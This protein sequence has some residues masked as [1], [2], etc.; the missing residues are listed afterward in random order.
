MHVTD[1]KAMREMDRRAVSEYG[2]PG[3]LLMENAAMAVMKHLDLSLHY[4]VLVCGPGN[5]GGDGFA[6][7]WKLQKLNKEVD[8]FYVSDGKEPEGEA[9]VYYDIIRKTDVPVEVV[10]DA[11]SLWSFVEALRDADLVVDALL[12]TGISR[13]ISPLFREVIEY[14]NDFSE[15]IL[16]VDVPSGLSADS[17]LAMPLAVKASKTVTFEAM[18]KGLL[19]YGAIPCT[20]ILVMEKIGIP[21]R[22]KEELAGSVYLTDEEDVMKILPKREVT[23][24]KNHYGRVL[25]VAG[26]RG[27]TGAAMLSAEAALA[28]GS[29][30]VT[31]CSYNETM[32]IL[33][34]RLTEIMSLYENN[35][36]E[37][38][39]KAD[40]VA[41]GPGLGASRD[42][43][44]L[45]LRV[46][47]TLQEEEK[48]GSTL[49]I[50]ADGLNVLEGKC[51]ILKPLCF[52]VILTPHPGEMA[53][54]TGK[55]KKEIEE[56]RIETA[57]GFAKEH[58]V[59]VVLKGYHT[60]ITDGERVYINSTG[61]SAMA[62][63]G[64]GDALT[65]IIASLSGQG[66][67]P[68]EA[69]VLGTYIHGCIGDQLAKERYSVKASEIIE[70]IPY[71]MK[72]LQ[73]R[74]KS[75]SQ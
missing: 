43:L 26:S 11:E 27:F 41:F 38:V 18:K 20:G 64:M 47:K 73:F 8:V 12:G 21:D 70:K 34:P 15:K 65:G 19:S 44:K 36:E 31:L 48:T 71:Y 46:I 17:G 74:K 2:I 62:Q 57:K 49:V 61:T 14:M 51:E 67:P 59:I 7:A 16:S 1:V 24:H 69:A 52:H 6:L 3:I 37:G 9:K 58:G 39:R 40:I 72:K 28:T 60:V 22:L 13:E 63:G 68:F 5:N 54:L 32:G 30:L 55:S 4:F 45:L 56:N 33:V 50:D 35:L 75:T 10:S 29:G 53:R 23:G 42:T 25:V 66:T